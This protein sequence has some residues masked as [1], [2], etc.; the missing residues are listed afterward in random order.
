[1]KISKGMVKGALVS[2][3]FVVGSLA[4]VKMTKKAANR[5]A[6]EAGQALEKYI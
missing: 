6:P 3:A 4:V 2:F 1:M 5:Y